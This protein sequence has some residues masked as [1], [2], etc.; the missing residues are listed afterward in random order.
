V[1]TRQTEIDA[2]GMILHMTVSG[3]LSYLSIYTRIYSRP[4]GDYIR[5]V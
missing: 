5:M 4:V 1:A 3:I 2:S